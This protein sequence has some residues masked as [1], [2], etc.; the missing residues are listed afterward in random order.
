[1]VRM[2]L[3]TGALAACL[4]M[5]ATANAGAPT[6]QPSYFVAAYAYAGVLRGPTVSLGNLEYRWREDYHDFRPKFVFGFTHEAR[7]Y[8][9]SIVKGWQFHEN[10]RIALSSG[11][12]TYQ[13]D[14][15]EHDLGSRTEFLS[16]IELSLATHAGQ[17]VGLSFQH[18]SNAHLGRINPGSEILQLSYWFPIH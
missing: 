16:S 10:W 14:G 12:G 17:R 8:N 18:I 7:Y 2:I 1:M 9:L 4:A 11:P 6:P 3:K 5:H 13:R 15:S